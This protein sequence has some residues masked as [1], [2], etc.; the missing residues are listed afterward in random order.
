M[1][2]RQAGKEGDLEEEALL[3]LRVHCGDQCDLGGRRIVRKVNLKSRKRS[4][5]NLG[6]G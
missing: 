6:N 4:A 2:V 5:G 3:A 1:M